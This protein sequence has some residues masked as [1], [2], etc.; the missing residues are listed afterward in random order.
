M[1]FGL[2]GCYMGIEFKIL[3][4]IWIECYVCLRIWGV[5]NFFLLANRWLRFSNKCNRCDSNNKCLLNRW[6]CQMETQTCL[7]LHSHHFQMAG[8]HS[9]QCPSHS[10]S[11]L[12][13]SPQDLY[14]MAWQATELIQWDRFL[15]RAKLWVIS[16]GNKE[17]MKM[18]FDM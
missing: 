12:S 5:I 9:N 2:T 18:F 8:Y 10:S 6:T 3:T 13:L 14:L 1:Y 4:R 17:K 11:I 16:C 7:P 15:A